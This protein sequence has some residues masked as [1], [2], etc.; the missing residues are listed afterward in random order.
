MEGRY[1]NACTAEMKSRAVVRMVTN[2]RVLEEGAESVL[3]G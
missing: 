3:T 1:L 2:T